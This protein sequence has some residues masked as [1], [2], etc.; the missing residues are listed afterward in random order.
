METVGSGIKNTQIKILEKCIHYFRV[1]I[2]LR[3]SVV[4][5]TFLI[6][7][8]PRRNRSPLTMFFKE[9]YERSLLD[10]YLFVYKRIVYKRELCLPSYSMCGNVEK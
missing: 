3:L 6:Q 4:H 2:S 9:D 10:T 5:F 1:P 8:V 7:R